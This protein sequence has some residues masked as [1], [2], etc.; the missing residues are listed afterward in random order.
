MCFAVRKQKYFAH[1]AVSFIFWEY[2]LIY[3]LLPLHTLLIFCVIIVVAVVVSFHSTY[4]YHR[5]SVG[6]MKITDWP[7]SI[8]NGK[9]REKLRKKMF[10]QSSRPSTCCHICYEWNE[11]NRVVANQHHQPNHSAVSGQRLCVGRSVCFYGWGKSAGGIC[12]K[13][14]RKWPRK[15]HRQN[16]FCIGLR[17]ILHHFNWTQGMLIWKYEMHNFYTFS[18]HI[19]LGEVCFRT[20]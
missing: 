17:L 4:R 14:G 2:F 18:S 3:F 9:Q 16:G 12:G 10:V 19:S 8:I 11:Y 1:L 13:S 6:L 15:T 5:L 7:N 20:F